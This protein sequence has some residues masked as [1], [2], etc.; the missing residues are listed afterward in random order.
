MFAKNGCLTPFSDLGS[1]ASGVA[2]ALEHGQ[3]DAG[4]DEEGAEEMVER[5]LLRG[6]LGLGG[7]RGDQ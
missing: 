7:R 3:Q 2:S 5:A 1:W 6:G 4:G